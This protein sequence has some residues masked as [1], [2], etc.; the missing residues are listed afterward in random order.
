MR[1]ERNMKYLYSCTIKGDTI[2]TA[3]VVI[4]YP[5]ASSSIATY[6]LVN[7]WLLNINKICQSGQ[8]NIK[9]IGEFDDGEVLNNAN[10]G[11][12]SIIA[13]HT[14]SKQSIAVT[15]KNVTINNISS[16]FEQKIKTFDE[17]Y[18][19]KQ[20]VLKSAILQLKNEED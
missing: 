16:E 9:N 11:D 4:L 20:F 2:P 14:E 7:S 15:L 5:N 3:N 8:T 12:L 17:N 1:K 19:A 10:F 18:T 13:T 6:S